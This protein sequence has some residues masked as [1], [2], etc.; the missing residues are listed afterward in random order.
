VINIAIVTEL[1]R[2]NTHGKETRKWKV[3]LQRS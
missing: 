2:S 3:E 1:R